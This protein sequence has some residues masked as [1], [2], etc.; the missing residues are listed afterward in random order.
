MDSEKATL[1]KILRGML[2]YKPEDGISAQEFLYTNWMLRLG[3]PVLAE[4][5]ELR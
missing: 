4:M 1:L 5:K 2:E 3:L